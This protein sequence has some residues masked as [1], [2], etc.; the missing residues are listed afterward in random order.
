MELGSDH[1]VGDVV[2]RGG[3]GGCVV[4][5][6]VEVGVDGVEGIDGLAGGVLVGV[7]V[8]VGLEGGGV[9]EVVVKAL[10]SLGGRRACRGVG[11]WG[12]ACRS[13]VAVLC[14]LRRLLRGGLGVELRVLAAR[15]H[16]SGITGLWMKPFLC[17]CGRR[18]I[19]GAACF[20]ALESTWIAVSSITRVS[21]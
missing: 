15:S 20:P 19:G 4:G 17:D 13:V 12:R 7:R 18:Q 14:A 8:V 6:D 1:G 21:G 11:R 10:V 9:V 5:H 2:G 16:R 3:G